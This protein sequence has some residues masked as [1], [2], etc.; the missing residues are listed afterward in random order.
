[1]Y[2]QN[3]LILANAFD[4]FQMSNLSHEICDDS[5]KDDDDDD[6]DDDDEDGDDYDDDDYGD[7]D[8]DDDGDDNDDD[9]HVNT[10]PLPSYIRWHIRPVSKKVRGMKKQWTP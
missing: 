6:D 7:D 9:I 5:D 2:F 10:L 8:D 4:Q 3:P 1:M